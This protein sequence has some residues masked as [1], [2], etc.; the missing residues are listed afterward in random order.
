MPPNGSDSVTVRHVC[1]GQGFYLPAHNET[2]TERDSHGGGSEPDTTAGEGGSGQVREHSILTAT[3]GLVL[4][5]VEDSG[6]RNIAGDTIDVELRGSN[7]RGGGQP[8][9]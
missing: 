1:A 3:V 9:L 8:T 5:G 7:I 2:P 6:D 4:P